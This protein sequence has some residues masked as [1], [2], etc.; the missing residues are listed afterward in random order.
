MK[1]FS[2]LAFFIAITTGIIAA[3]CFEKPLS[4]REKFSQYF[5][6]HPYSNRPHFISDL[7]EE[8]AETDRPDLAYEQDFLRTLNPALGRPTPEV[9]PAIIQQMKMQQSHTTMSIPGSLTAPWVACGAHYVGGRTRALIFDPNDSLHKIKVWACA[10][11]GGLWYNNDIS[12]VNSSWISVSDLWANLS[13]TCMAFD[14]NNF[15]IAYVGTG[16]SGAVSSRG[17]GIWKT[18]NGGASWT[19]ISSTTAFYYINDLVVRNENGTSVVYAAVDGDYYAG[20]WSGLTYIGL[21]R[22]TNGGTSWSQVLPT[23]PGQSIRYIPADIEIS[24]SN[25]IWVGTKGNPYSASDRGGGRILYSDNGTTWTTSNT[26]SVTNGTGKVELVCAPSNSNYV[27]AIIEDNRTVGSM[28]KTTDNG[29]TWS[30][31]SLPVDADSGIPSSDFS[32]GQAAYDLIMAVDPNVETTLIVG[33]ID[34]FKSSDSGSTWNQLSHWYGGFGYPNVHADQHAIMYQ[35]GSSS[36]VIFGNDGGNC[37]SAN[38]GASFYNRNK[39]YDVTQYYSCAIHPYPNSNI[40][41]GGAQDNGTQRLVGSTSTSQV[42][43]GDGAFCFIDQ[44]T[45]NYQI[46]SY[47]YNCY[48]LSTNG[49]TSYFSTQLNAD[50]TTGKFINPSAYDNNLHILYSCKDASSICRIKNITST[51]SS[52]QTVIISGLGNQASHIKV[53]PYTKTSSTL[54]IGTDVG[55][56]FKV[57]NADNTPTVTNITGSS[58]PTGSISC[59]EIGASE[60]ELLVTFFNYGIT[61]VW[62]TSNG[63]TTWVNKEGNLPDMPVRWALFNPRNRNEVILATELGVWKTS[64]LGISSPTWSTS[65]NGLFNVR[66]DM[67]QLR[68]SDNTVLAATYGR[69]LFSCN[70]F[71]MSAAFTSSKTSPCLNDTLTLIDTSSNLPISWKWRIT[72]STFVFVNGTNANSQ[73]PKVLFSSLGS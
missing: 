64:N 30:D 24:S 56:L 53:S 62:Y 34:L 47:V 35:P 63:G 39:N 67:L 36:T 25:R 44:T 40:Y 54:F 57:T 42:Y 29:N 20:S 12:D 70:G 17:A 13:I 21:Q 33:T 32:R 46:A 59:V 23:I 71:S 9:L 41:L 55:K 8:M 18:T 73:N 11:T 6:E 10:A 14:P 4:K 48:N 16:E 43:G 28:K 37:F 45:P 27:Y 3:F 5:N 15:Q 31:I 72:P 52:V 49:G 50:Q 19:Q 65:N 58:F 22:S 2:K 7:D 1:N 51:P 60:S 26:T 61:S 68:S 66:V 69:G 38:S